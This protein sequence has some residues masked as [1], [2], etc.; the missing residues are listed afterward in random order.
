MVT[1]DI[2]MAMVLLVSRQQKIA[3]Q[4]VQRP[5][6]TSSTSVAHQAKND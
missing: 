4:S 6:S 2:F 5:K 1:L 3:C